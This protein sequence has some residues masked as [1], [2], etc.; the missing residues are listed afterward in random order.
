MFEGIRKEAIDFLIG[1]KLNN[2]ETYYRDHLDVYEK[3]I[4]IPMRELCAALA[5][6]VH[7]VDPDLDTRPGSVISRLRRDTRFTQDKSPFRD[8][9]WMGWRY[10]GER[11][12]EGFHM[13]WGFGPSWMGWGCGSYGTDRPLMDNFRQTLIREPDRVR[14]AIYAKNF[15]GRYVISGE[16]YKKMTVPESVPEGLRSFYTLKY[17]NADLNATEEDWHLLQ[18][19]EFLER[20]IEEINAMAPL[21]CL[22][23]EIRAGDIATPLEAKQAESEPPVAEP[24]GSTGKVVVRRLEEFEF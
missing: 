13:Y 19:S 5:S 20:M 4:K 6:T 24:T 7:A 21:L 9:V 11:R 2:N 22:M 1:I 23:K 14:D 12:S 10:P 17:L 3:E 18:T 15:Q 16:H 8:H